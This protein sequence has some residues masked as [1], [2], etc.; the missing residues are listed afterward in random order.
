MQNK[1]GCQDTRSYFFRNNNTTSEM[2]RKHGG[3]KITF[4]EQIIRK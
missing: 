4:T 1:D 3:G 2:E